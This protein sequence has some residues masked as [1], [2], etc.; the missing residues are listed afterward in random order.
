VASGEGID[1]LKIPDT[2]LEP[3]SW[4]D[5]DGWTA[6]NHEAALA[7]FRASCEPFNRQ[8]Q[9]RDTR[10]VASALKQVCRR[11]ARAGPLK[12]NKARAFFEDNFQ[13]VRIAKLGES[14]GLLTGYYE[15]IVDGSRFPSPE[16]HVPIYRRPRDLVIKDQRPQP[17]GAIPNRAAVGRLNAKKEF[18]PYYDRLAI[19]DGALDG[20]KLEICYVADP[21]EAMSIQIQGS[22]RVRLEDGTLVRINYDAHNGHNYSSVGRVLIERNLVPRD[23]MS[24]DRIKRW[25][26]A[27][28]DQAKEVRGANKSY[29]FFRITGLNNQDEPVGAQGVRLT[30]GRSIAVDRTHVYGTPFFIESDL[31]I[32]GARPNTKFRRLM[33]GQDTGSA[34]IG[35]AR[36]DLY[37]GAGD[38][39]GKVA[40][41]M[42]HQ[43]RFVMLLPRE[44]DMVAAGRKMPLPPV[45]PAI[46]DAVAAKTSGA[47]VDGEKANNAGSNAGNRKAENGKKSPPKVRS[48]VQPGR[49]KHGS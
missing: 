23:E 18:E 12:G 3:I 11:L 21:F 22:A 41:R 38:E 9:L 24:M 32:E 31:P 33:V 17:A 10:P 26:Q 6:D 29:V 42:R 46:P 49:P 39:A 28:P 15:P 48:Q 19:E 5:V 34:I 36:A 40:G 30:P 44:L 4:S 25:M 7:T 43:G 14:S 27:N 47:K 37:W 16:F 2:Q 13:P 1:P 45:K 20:R 35:P 8:G